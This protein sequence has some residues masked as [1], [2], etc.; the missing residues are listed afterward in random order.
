MKKF[1]CAVLASSTPCRRHIGFDSHKCW[2]SLS[3]CRGCQISSVTFFKHVISAFSEKQ[4]RW[5]I[6]DTLQIKNTRIPLFLH[7]VVMKLV[8]HARIYSRFAQILPGLKGVLH[9][10][11]LLLIFSARLH[12]RFGS[13]NHASIYFSP[14][15][16]SG[17]RFSGTVWRQN[18]LMKSAQKLI[19]CPI[20]HAASFCVVVFFQK[21]FLPF[22]ATP[23][24]FMLIC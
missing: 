23:R 15:W 5:V 22:F 1:C 11:T 18:A 4:L 7:V 10:A 16:V 17:G 24:F 8:P 13:L 2:N 6:I 21:C 20:F 12:G 19:R 9:L 3:F 14:I